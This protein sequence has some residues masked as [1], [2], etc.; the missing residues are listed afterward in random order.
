[1][2]IHPTAIVASGANIDPTV[3][4]G[5]YAIIE[6][7]VT[8][9]AGCVIHPHAVIKKF[10]TLGN[11]NLIH[12]GAVI[13]DEPQDLAFLGKPSYV[14][15]GD[16]NIIREY[17]TIHRGTTPDSQTVLGN[18]CFLMA[19]SHV[20]HN[21]RLGDRVI[22]ANGMLLAGHVTVG[23]NAFLSGN[24]VVHQFT[25]IGRLCMLSGGS[26]MVMDLPPFMMGH[27]DSDCVGINRV[28]LRRAGY[29]A[30]QIMEVRAAY[31]L[32]Y[33]SG[34]SFTKAI[35]QLE[36]SSPNELV[37]EIIDFIKAPSKRG[38]AG[39]P[40]GARSKSNRTSDDE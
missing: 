33:L 30:Q 12:A 28:G 34:M 1:M 26:R 19:C 8:I 15:L 36:E 25:R 31:R 6:D 14:R 40:P 17:V 37:Q 10:T 7:E 32:L 29:S 22:L 21:C 4:I 3:E 5:P 11:N 38:I 23:N 18:H 20:G 35:G 16:H 24:A 2:S 39:P 9:G 27:G 13:G